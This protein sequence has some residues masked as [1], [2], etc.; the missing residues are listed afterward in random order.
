MYAK[1]MQVNAWLV[2]SNTSHSTAGGAQTAVFTM[3]ASDV[4]TLTAK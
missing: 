1:Y 4:Q 2:I 3:Y